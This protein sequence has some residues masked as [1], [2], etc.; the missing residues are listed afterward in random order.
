MYKKDFYVKLLLQEEQNGPVK[1]SEWQ[2][3]L[4]QGGFIS[5][6]RACEL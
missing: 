6:S 2:P 4:N 1:P 3:E 5:S